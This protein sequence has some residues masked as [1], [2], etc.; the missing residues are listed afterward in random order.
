MGGGEP[1]SRGG[2]GGLPAAGTAGDRD[3]TNQRAQ[4]ERGRSAPCG[5]RDPLPGT[6]EP[7]ESSP[8]SP[9][10]VVEGPCSTN[11]TYRAVSLLLL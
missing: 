1:R 6:V 4:L 9:L 3:R 7:S 2:R 11:F 8:V 5:V 10:Q